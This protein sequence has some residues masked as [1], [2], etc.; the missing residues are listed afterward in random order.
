MSRRKVGTIRFR[1]TLRSTIGDH[2]VGRNYMINILLQIF[3]ADSFFADFIADFFN[4]SVLIQI[5]T[6]QKRLLLHKR[7]E[8]ILKF[9]TLCECT[10]LSSKLCRANDND[11]DFL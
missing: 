10:V 6:Y 1:F 3:L 8:R 7:C 9:Y 5:K 2:T 4:W 11:F